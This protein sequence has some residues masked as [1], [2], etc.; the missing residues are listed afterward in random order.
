[1]SLYRRFKDRFGTAGVVLGVITLILALGGS[2]IAASKLTGP[3]KKEVAKIAKKEAQKYANSN[4]GAPG[5]AGTNGTNGKDGT[6]GTN[7]IDGEDGEAGADGDDGDSVTSSAASAGECANGG[8]KFTAANG[9]SKACNGAPGAPGP[10]GS[11][12]TA[13]G[14]LPPTKTEAGSWYM[15]IDREIPAFGGLISGTDV[16]SFPIPLAVGLPPEKTLIVEKDESP[17]KASCDDGVGTPAGPGHPEADPGF[18]CVFVGSSAL[19]IPEG[20]LIFPAENA[21]L[22]T[23]GASTAGARLIGLAE[24]PADKGTEAWGTFAV[25]G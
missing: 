1:M 9:T 14:T 4:P 12:W 13:G 8:T 5:T 23:G 19:P 21:S 16:V 10:E 15:T 24:E 11:P 22:T 7:G 20:I 2:A 6:N 25:T 3:Q 18:L 17:V